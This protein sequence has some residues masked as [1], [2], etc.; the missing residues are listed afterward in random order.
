[1]MECQ[2]Q[3][4]QYTLPVKKKRHFKRAL[5]WWPSK[6]RRQGGCAI[7]KR[8]GLKFPQEGQWGSIFKATDKVLQGVA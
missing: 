1:M 2:G 3:D 6:T 7:S 4:R 8:K 5:G